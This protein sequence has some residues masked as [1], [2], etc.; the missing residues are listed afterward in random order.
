MKAFYTFLL[1]FILL[2][3]SLNEASAQ[4]AQGILSPSRIEVTAFVGDTVNTYFDVINTGTV[5]FYPLS[6]FSSS[7]GF[8]WPDDSELPDYIQPGTSARVY[9]TYTPT[10]PGTHRGN[11][12]MKI[13][14]EYPSVIMTGTAILYGDVNMDDKVDITDIVSL[15]DHVLN[16]G[17]ATFSTDMNGDGSVTI[18]DIVTLIDVLLNSGAANNNGT[19]DPNVFE[20]EEFE[21]NGVTFK[22]IAVE[23]GTFNMGGNDVDNT[24]VHQVQL[25]NFLIAETEVTQELWEAVM[26]SNPS[27]HTGNAKYPVECVSWT[28]CQQFITTLNQLTGRNFRLPTEA[29]WEY[30]ARGGKKTHGY[31]YSGSSSYSE[32]AWCENNSNDLTHAVRTKKRNELGTYD[33]SGNVWEWCQDWYAPYESA[34]SGALVNPTGPETGTERIVR[35]GCMRG[36]S[37]MCDVAYRM[38]YSPGTWRVDVGMRLAM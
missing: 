20:D 21:V 4:T 14:N 33:M 26:G 7:Y 35:G 23:G 37:R 3:P 18:T 17:E 36:H 32:V 16:N 11:Y 15:I 1:A 13:G 34:S 25:S 31:K 12:T 2:S 29:E 28:D 5:A 6:S 10:L 9:V 24:P 22:M 19:I 8:F 30:A 38:Y 27:D